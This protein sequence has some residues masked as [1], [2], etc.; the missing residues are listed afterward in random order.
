VAG[1]PPPDVQWFDM[2]VRGVY[3]L[4]QQ[5]IGV[6]SGYARLRTVG[7][8]HCS[9]QRCVDAERT[10]F[11][12]ATRGA[13]RAVSAW[14]GLAEKGSVVVQV[15]QLVVGQISLPVDRLDTANRLASAAVHAFIG[16]DVHRSRA[17]ID[18]VDWAFLNTRLV[19]HIYAS[20]ADH[21][22]HRL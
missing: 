17:L 6:I 9:H 21:V 11:G 16:I 14:E 4:A 10:Y 13:Q 12:G 1:F 19:H 3:A 8:W 22:G 15:L 5:P 2:D 20:G 7:Y 18:A